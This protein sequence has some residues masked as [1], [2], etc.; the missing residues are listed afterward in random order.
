MRATSARMTERARA[1]A[2]IHLREAL[3]LAAVERVVETGERGADR[4]R[5][6][7]HGGEARAQHLEAARHGQRAVGR[8][9]GG[10]RVGR[11]QRGGEELVERA[12]LRVVEAHGALDA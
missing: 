2:S 12:A 7:A 6:R 9:G 11:L 1:P 8:A 4:R 5:R 3:L 10:E